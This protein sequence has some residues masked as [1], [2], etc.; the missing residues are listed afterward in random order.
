M[1]ARPGTAGRYVWLWLLGI[2]VGYVEGAVVV[3]LRAL[4]YPEGFHFP[5]LLISDRLAAVEIAREAASILLLSAAARLAGE[6]FLERF[7]AFM[8]LFGVWDLVYYVVLA[9]LVGWPA[10]L[11][12]WDILFLIPVPWVGPVWAP[13]LVSV[14]LV[15]AG[16]WLYWT[17]ERPRHVQPLDWAVEVAAGLLVVGA[18]VAEWRV[19]P[20]QRVPESFPAWILLGGLA[21]GVAWL[22]RVERRERPAPQP[23]GATSPGSP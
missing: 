12:D 11:A 1:P 3:Y 9:V 20:E 19:V 2:A 22:L 13:C 14:V 18:F 16:S 10:S 15:V 17:A 21:L 7:G 23:D 5:V 8:V 4:Y 6:R